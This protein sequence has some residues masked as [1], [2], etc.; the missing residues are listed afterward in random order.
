MLCLAGCS[1]KSVQESSPETERITPAKEGADEEEEPT[2]PQAAETGSRITPFP[3]QTA[4]KGDILIPSAPGQT[5]TSPGPA[6][7]TL[8]S[9][10][11]IVATDLH[12]LA[13]ELT[14][15]GEAFEE[16]I[17]S[18][19][20]KVT[21]YVWEITDAF[22]DEVTEAK[23]QALVLLGDLTLNGELASHEALAEKLKKVERAGIP[24]VVIPGNHDI[25]NPQA[26]S[27]KGKEM[28]PAQTT[29]AEAF[30]R[31]YGEF[32]YDEARSRDPNSLSYLYELTNGTRL[33]MLDSCQYENGNLVGGMIRQ[34]SYEWIEEVLEEAVDEEHPVLVCAHHNLLE[35]SRV[36]EENC[37]IEHAEELEQTLESWGTSLFL[38]GHLHVQHARE[39]DYYGL[40]EIVTSALSIY[41]CQYGILDFQDYD[42]YSYQAKVTDVTSWADSKE[43]PDSNLQEFSEYASDFLQETYYRQAV[44]DLQD[45]ELTAE[46]KEEMAELYAV[47]NVAAVEGHACD[48]AD[49]VLEQEAYQ[50]WMDYERTDTLAMY[51]SEILED[52][53][54]DFREIREP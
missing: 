4:P 27:F 25:N 42:T 51:L 24:V 9:D 37:T 23:P 30:A 21:D 48:L 43:I 53:E 19:D 50:Q 29:T 16:K 52:A 38:S 34:E 32:G 8:L 36:Y 54:M 1:G 47:V 28:V 15:F 2:A 17:H 18:D 12:Y 31:I 41:P 3:T 45:Y 40:Q 39:D 5:E 7:S 6:Y 11:I 49:W 14:D 26:V 33:L 22:L 46:E 35:E 44:E 20:G 10:Q 13:K